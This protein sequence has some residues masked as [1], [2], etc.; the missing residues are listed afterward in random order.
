[1][2]Y[3]Y[4]LQFWNLILKMFY[5][6]LKNSLIKCQTSSHLFPGSVVALYNTQ[7]AM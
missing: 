7:S 2:E 1:M 6:L 3:T 4:F 5:H